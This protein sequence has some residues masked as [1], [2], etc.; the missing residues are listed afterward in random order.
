MR[1][2]RQSETFFLGGTEVAAKL[3][4]V[5]CSGRYVDDLFDIMKLL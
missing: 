2:K 5:G 3:L 1:C 4:F